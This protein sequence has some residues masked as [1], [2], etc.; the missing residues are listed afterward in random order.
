MRRVL[1]VITALSLILSLAACAPDNIIAPPGDPDAS[2]N[3]PQSGDGT[4]DKK[5]Q[6][7][8]AQQTA[9]ASQSDEQLTDGARFLK[10]KTKNDHIRPT[11]DIDGQNILSFKTPQLSGVELSFF[12]PEDSAFKAGNMSEKEWLS[13]LEKEYGLKIKYTLR[14][15][16][17]LYSSQLIAMN[18]GRTLDIISTKAQ[19]SA[20]ALSLMQS[21]GDIVTPGADAPVS[22]RVFERTGGKLFTA[23]GNCRVLWYN[24][25]LTGQNDLFSMYTKNEWTSDKLASLYN[26]IAG[27]KTRLLQCS[28][29]LAF[30][31]AGTVQGSGIS[32]AG[33]V[34]SIIDEA[35]IDTFEAFGSVFNKDF[36][37]ANGDFSF[38]A[39]NTAL[40]FSESPDK[41][42]FEIGWAPIP[43]FTE[44]G[45][46]V[47]E[48]FGS[49][50]GLSRTAS[51]N[52]RNAAAAFMALW[53]ARYSESRSDELIYDIGLTPTETDSYLTFCETD[54]ELYS[55]DASIAQVF[56]SEKMPVHLYGTPETVYNTYGAAFAR[57]DIINDRYQ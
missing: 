56:S 53:C 20:A 9:G 47:G 1:V 17:T 40:V 57:T 54:G 41:G 48:I 24:K 3:G 32:G 11:A 2:V 52:N 12:T 7:E 13:A 49:A 30:G 4:E 36:G 29:W 50:M 8:P 6:S 21:A 51:G 10:N 33:Y 38:K 55:A 23:K 28:D 19:D 37:T 35:V 18:S 15:D 31:S 25:S 45:R 16:S 42:E 34:M 43:K 39:G 14:P 46:Y 27:E 5:P 44:N 26:S 22:S